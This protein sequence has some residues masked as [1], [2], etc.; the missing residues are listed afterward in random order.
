MWLLIVGFLVKGTQAWVGC[1]VVSK[2]GLK[3]SFGESENIIKI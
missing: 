3:E 2:E 1:R